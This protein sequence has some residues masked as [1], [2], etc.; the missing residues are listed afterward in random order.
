MQTRM[1]ASVSGVDAKNFYSTFRDHWVTDLPLLLC[2]GKTVIGIGKLIELDK[3]EV[4]LS[5]LMIADKYQN[6][7][8]G[9]KLVKYLMACAILNGYKL[10]SL[11][12]KIDNP[13]GIRFFK[14]L[15]FKV[16]KIG[17]LTLYMQRNL[18]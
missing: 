13:I 16:T 6:K 12:V 9:S 8:Y 2:H 15:G 17:E 10:M 1:N 4:Y 7:G 18:V 14:R 11:E 3:V 5:S